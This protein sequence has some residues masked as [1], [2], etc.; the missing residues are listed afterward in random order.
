MKTTYIAIAAGAFL[1]LYYLRERW[2]ALPQAT[3]FDQIIQVA[4]SLGIDVEGKAQEYAQA[5]AKKYVADHWIT[6]AIGIALAG[7]GSAYLL[8][9]VKA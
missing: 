3:E 9:K 6:F 8:Q 4:H 7:I 1:L 5:T 2:Q